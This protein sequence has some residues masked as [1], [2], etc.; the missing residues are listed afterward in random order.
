MPELSRFY[1]V[2]IYMFAKDHL[3]PH[4]HAKYGEYI[5][6]VNIR[7]GEMIEGNL[8]R[9][10]LRLVQDWIELHADELMANWQD[11]LDTAPFM[12]DDGAWFRFETPTKRAVRVAVLPEL[13][14]KLRQ[15]AHLQ[16]VS[17]ED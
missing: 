9:I 14:A 11:N 13:A 1:G 15:I 12:E 4:C 8:P 7:T 6:L 16:G 5:G 17:L 3:P 2:V 10:S